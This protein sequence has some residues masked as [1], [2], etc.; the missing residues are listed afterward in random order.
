MVILG[1]GDGFLPLAKLGV[2]VLLVEDGAPAV[3]DICGV[4]VLIPK[5]GRLSARKVTQP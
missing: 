2:R 4:T 3:E 1:R 5:G